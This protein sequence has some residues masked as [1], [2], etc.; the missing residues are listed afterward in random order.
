MGIYERGIIRVG[1]KLISLSVEPED[2]E[3]VVLGETVSDLQ[4]GISIS[5]GTVSGTLKYVTGFTGYSSDPDLQSGNF[6]ALKVESE[7][8][9]T[10]KVRMGENEKTLDEDMNFVA[11]I[12]DKDTQTITVTTTIGV[13]SNS[14]TLALTGLT[15][16]ES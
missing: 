8:G 16:N 5:N 4:T 3:T 1:K 14:V 6:L 2:G 7:T 13:H 9:A 11:R 12:T 15:L 10:V